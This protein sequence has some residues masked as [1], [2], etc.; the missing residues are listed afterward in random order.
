M[1]SS[2][3]VIQTQLPK[4]VVQSKMLGLLNFGSLM[5]FYCTHI[6][7]LKAVELVLIMLTI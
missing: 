5:D 4:K 2:I 3:A 6:R 7:S 1:Y